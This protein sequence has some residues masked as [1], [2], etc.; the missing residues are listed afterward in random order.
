MSAGAVIQNG[1][2]RIAAK[3]GLTAGRYRVSLSAPEP[4]PV[5]A[6]VMGENM[7]PAADRIPMKYNVQSELFVEVKPGVNVFD[8]P[9]VSD[10]R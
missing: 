10:R 6:P 2:F 9:V 7:Q 8:F 1:A 4:A 3:D 5:A